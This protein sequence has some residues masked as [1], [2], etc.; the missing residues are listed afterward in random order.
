M[1]F[2]KI[3]KINIQ[4][5]PDLMHKQIIKEIKVRNNNTTSFRF[6]LSL[7]KHNWIIIITQGRHQKK[8]HFQVLI[9]SSWNWFF[10]KDF[11]LQ[12]TCTL[13]LNWLFTF[14]DKNK[15]LASKRHITYQQKPWND[16]QCS[17]KCGKASYVKQCMCVL[18]AIH[19]WLIFDG[20]NDVELL[21]IDP[22]IN[23][24]HLLSCYILYSPWSWSSIPSWIQE[25]T[26]L[27]QDL[28]WS[29]P[30]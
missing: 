9:K 8:S 13:Y 11:H 3:T 18:P 22:K 10:D 19:K 16:I 4:S 29:P 6:S 27:E 24:A 30:H 1:D 14:I 20:L 7:Q 21:D 12:C 5:S 28:A 25:A 23:E 15:M 26:Q 17:D 2:L